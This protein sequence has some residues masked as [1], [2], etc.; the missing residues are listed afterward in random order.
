V[1]NG[2]SHTLGKRAWAPCPAS[3]EA[4]TRCHVSTGFLMRLRPTIADTIAAYPR[5]YWANLATNSRVCAMLHKGERRTLLHQ[6]PRYSASVH[7]PPSSRT[8]RPVRVGRWRFQGD[9]SG[10][11]GGKTR[12]LGPWLY[13]RRRQL[14][15]ACCRGPLGSHGDNFLDAGGEFGRLT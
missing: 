11:V 1:G 12:G 3:G 4:L 8:F 13:I 6:C 9:H 2:S 10:V 15:A 5:P 14:A 7:S